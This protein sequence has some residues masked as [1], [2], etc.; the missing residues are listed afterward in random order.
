MAYIAIIAIWNLSPPS[1][2]QYTMSVPGWQDGEYDE[3]LGYHYAG[4]RDYWFGLPI[5]TKEYAEKVRKY[6]DSQCDYH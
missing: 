6:K 2:L 4:L 5:Q 3:D 1:A